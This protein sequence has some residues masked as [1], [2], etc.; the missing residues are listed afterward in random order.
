MMYHEIERKFLVETM[1]NLKGVK[2]VLQERYFLQHGDLVEERIQAYGTIFEY[3]MKTA[4]S[5][6][7]W[8]REKRLLTGEQFFSLQKKASPA[9]VRESYSLSKK[10]PRVSIKVYQGIYQ[11]LVYAEVEFDSLKEFE[12]FKPLSWMGLEI[13][14]SPLGR[15]SWLLTFDRKHFLKALAAEKEKLKHYSKGDVL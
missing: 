1:P 3:E 15:E 4:V 13:T 6:K 10:N 12:S 2:P 5:P 14:N 8:R 9:I 11:G 7:E